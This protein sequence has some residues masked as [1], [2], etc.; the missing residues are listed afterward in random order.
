MKNILLVALVF[1]I[2][3]NS[4]ASHLIGGE[5]TYTCLGSDQYEISLTIYR[6]C[7][8]S[9][10]NGT[11]FD[12][13]GVITI[14]DMNNN[15]LQVLEH[16]SVITEFIE[17]EYYSDSFTIDSN[18]C[19]EK[20]TYTIQTTLPDNSQGY[21]VVYQR[22]C[23]NVNLNN[24]QNPEEFGSSFITYIPSN[25][26]CNSS[27][28]FESN[29]P[30]ILCLSDQLEISQSASDVDGDLLVYSLVSPFHGS[31]NFDPTG[32][33]PPPYNQLPWAEGYSEEY[34]MDSNP[35]LSIDSETGLITGTPT[36]EGFYSIAINV[37]EFRNGEYL[38]EITRDFR[39]L[40]IDCSS[41]GYF[42]DGYFPGCTSD[43]ADNFDELATFD[44]GSCELAACPYFQFIEYNP[45]YTI[46][47]TELCITLVVEGCTNEIDPNYNPQAN[48][49]DGSCSSYLGCK[50]DWADN[51]DPLAIEDDGSCELTACANPA[52]LE[53]NP[54]YTLAN[55]SLCL[56]QLTI[57][58]CTNE[59]AC[60]FDSSATIDNGMCVFYNTYH[61][62]YLDGIP[63]FNDY[64]EPVIEY[65]P[66]PD[67]DCSSF[68]IGCIDPNACNY[69]ENEFIDIVNCEYQTIEVLQQLY[70]LEG[71]YVDPNTPGSFPAF[72]SAGQPIIEIWPLASP[73]L[74]CNESCYEYA[75][76]EN[77]TPI[78][79][80]IGEYLMQYVE[81]SIDDCSAVILGCT[82]S[83]ACNYQE[84]AT[85]N[86]GSCEYQT[87]EVFY[88]LH[89]LGG[90]EV[91][92]NTPGALPSFSA[93]GQPLS[94]FGPLAS[95][96]LNCNQDCYKYALDENYT[97]IYNEI[98]EY[99]MQYVEN[100]IEDCSAVILGCTNSNACNYQENAT[101][102]DGS[103]EH[104]SSEV[105][106]QL[107]TLA[108]IEVHPNTP[109]ALPSFSTDGQPLI[110]FGSVLDPTIQCEEIPSNFG[111]VDG[112]P[113]F[114]P[115][116]SG[117]S[118]NTDVVI[119]SFEPTD[120]LDDD[121]FLSVC[122]AMEHSY[123]GDLTM[124][125]TSPNGTTVSLHEFGGPATSQYLGI[126]IDVDS[127]L[128]EGECWTYCWT[129]TPTFGT[130]DQNLSTA[131]TSM[132][133]G[134][135]SPVGSFSDFAGSSANGTWTL[136]VTDN[137]A[138]DNGYICG[139]NIALNV[140]SNE[141]GCTSDWATNYDPMAV[142]DNGSC[143]LVAC[144]F[145]EFLEYNPNY[146][147]EDPTLCLTS[148]TVLG[149][150]NETAENYNADANTDDGT[151]DYLQDECNEGY[152]ITLQTGWNLFGYSCANSSEYLTEL[153]ESIIDV[154]IIIKNNAGDAYLPE[155]NYNG[156]GNL[157][158]G[159]GYQIK[160]TSQVTEFNICE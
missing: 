157:N 112:E 99:M 100:S 61:Q 139:W 77:Y 11:G 104:Q 67:T 29:P 114:L 71:V 6:E 49:D 27:P 145:P 74:N 135:Y 57:L 82:N 92:P 103:C 81:N 36:Q 39:F 12:S 1:V 15:E 9:N 59:I 54:N 149:C 150:T 93:D 131:S 84:N 32:T 42:P 140:M 21:K 117:V 115:D 142:V 125:L 46:I 119:Q 31:S 23:R 133:I 98:G 37:Q 138:S 14:Y 153:V 44:D 141:F 62:Q 40:V 51:Y 130:M 105:Y 91:H 124:T 110:V 76:D 17:D 13:D 156:I 154:I 65:G 121:D 8:S 129:S 70:T 86:D 101:V 10:S 26:S 132:P 146:T 53:Y 122:I 69:Q 35:V 33:Y 47:A 83:N 7:G 50:S 4:F 63:V 28:V 45:N 108:G 78:Y 52:F 38:G 94:V 97:P 25:V 80:E 89:T 144:P 20:G 64:G 79:N 137:L 19:V 24:L 87:T 55:P 151:C 106:Y 143:E 155:Y 88:Q 60:N 66:D 111:D 147:I 127:D 113:I 75:L 73:L 126:P 72:N 158:G 43:W 102:N 5:L 41:Y 120:I 58:G 56:T 3:F 90:I 48:T 95:P 160:I 68:E 96:L 22:C 134:D 18:V 107:H 123:L 2:N 85:V 34:P 148:L 159:Y 30:L 136:E 152:S 16:G 118:Y 116:G 109:G 128:T